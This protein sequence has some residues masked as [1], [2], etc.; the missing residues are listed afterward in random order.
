[1]TFDRLQISGSSGRGGLILSV[2]AVCFELDRVMSTSGIGTFRK[3]TSQCVMSAVE[4]RAEVVSGAE[5]RRDLPEAD[6]GCV[7]W[8]WA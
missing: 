3:L 6:F 8:N 4:G 7:G 2:L 1:M 5:N